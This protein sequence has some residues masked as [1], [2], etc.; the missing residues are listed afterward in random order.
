MYTRLP[1]FTTRRPKTPGLH[2]AV[3][4][5]TPPFSKTPSFGRPK[6]F[7]PDSTMP[8][9]PNLH[10]S[11]GQKKS[12]GHADYTMPLA[13]RATIRPAK[14]NPLGSR[15]PSN[16]RLPSSTNRPAKT[17]PLGTRCPPCLRLLSST[18]RPAKTI[19]LG[20]WNPPCSRASKLHHSAGQ[21]D[22]AGLLDFMMPPASKQFRWAPGL[23]HASGF[24]APRFG[25][26]K[27]IR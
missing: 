8:P 15:N 21:K 14:T 7:P 12:S 5:K 27:P 13:H 18:F 4:Y 10:H 19:P 20:S 2:H 3:G 24:Q 16:H 17:I 1:S 6:Q 9:A 22:C 25:Q 11:A 23:H 26:P